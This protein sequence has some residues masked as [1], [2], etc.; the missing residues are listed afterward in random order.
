M[1]YV[2]C[3]LSVWVWLNS[4]ATLT[5]GQPFWIGHFPWAMRG[6]IRRKMSG[7]NRDRRCTKESWAE[8][9][10]I[11]HVHSKFRIKLP[12]LSPTPPV[13]LLTCPPLLLSKTFTLRWIIYLPSLFCASLSGVN[14]FL[15]QIWRSQVR[16]CQCLNK[17][18]NRVNDSLITYSLSMLF[19]TEENP[20]VSFVAAIT[21][22]LMHII[23]YSAR[24]S[25]S[26]T[27][28]PKAAHELDWN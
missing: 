4:P 11:A 18:Q 14:R 3:H 13:H 22:S 16:F 28:C 15:G 20:A 26:F 1:C 21:G 9:C 12:S 17:G 10:L 2:I 8:G 23:F 5:S 25:L 19:Q 7:A 6:N 27:L 24:F